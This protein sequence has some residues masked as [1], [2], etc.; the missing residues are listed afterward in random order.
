[1]V[2]RKRAKAPKPSVASEPSTPPAREAPQAPVGPRLPKDAI[3]RI[4]IGQSF[5]EYDAALSDP[6]IYVHTPAL[7][8]ALDPDSEKVFFVGRRGT[9]KT[10][11]RKYCG[12]NGGVTR[13]IVPEI[14]SPSS[15]LQEIDLLTNVKGKPF[16]SLV[17]AFRRALQVE[18]LSMWLQD[19]PG[20]DRLPNEIQGELEAHASMDFD[21]RC[22]RIIA[23]ISGALANGDDEGWL[24]ESRTAKRVA[25]EMKKLS[26][27]GLA[28]HT[29]L[30]DSIDDYWEGSDEGLIYLTAFMH[31]CQEISQQIPWAR[32]I[33][34]LREN[35]YERVRAIDTESSRLETAVVGM[36]WNDR[37][38]LEVIEKRL[39]RN[40]TAKYGLRGATWQAFLS[41][42]KRR[43]IMSS[44]TARD[45][46]ATFLSIQAMR[47]RPLK[48]QVMRKFFSKT[49]SRHAG[50]SPTIGSVTSAT[51]TQRI[52]HRWQL[53]YP[54]FT[55]SAT[56]SRLA[57]LRT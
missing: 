36:E 32:A 6:S 15:T 45:G 54:V 21:L 5:A 34:F 19:R 48:E 16:K 33:I 42:Q 28:T 44:N 27:E 23:R 31:A 18:I 14:F 22:L 50:V 1:M 7:E 47:W 3:K 17:V 9:G 24:T 52:T 12:I 26:A 39:N 35:I 46:H 11:V 8:A 25:E 56:P 30:I 13:V 41:I 43:G 40:L 2:R 10:A 20:R 38:L 55:D 4:N 57:Q 49:S 53:S 29:V 37:Q 51:S